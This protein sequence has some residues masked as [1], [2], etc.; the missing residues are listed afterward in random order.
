M[1]SIIHLS[2]IAICIGAYLMYIN[3]KLGEIDSLRLKLVEYKTSL[4]Q[5]KELKTTLDSMLAAYNS[6]SEEDKLKLSKVVPEKF[7]NVLFVSDVSGIA[8]RNGM[9]IKSIKITDPGSTPNDQVTSESENTPYNTVVASFAFEGPYEQFIKMLKDMEISLQIMDVKT[10]SLN[11]IKK[12]NNSL[13]YGYS[14]DINTYY[15][16]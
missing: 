11:E 10:I 8:G 14:L 4:E 1:K 13:T 9:V 7:N 3:P 16:K 2:I 5:A 6:I 12:A 15:L